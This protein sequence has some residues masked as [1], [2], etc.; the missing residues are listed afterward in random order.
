ML[1]SR[2]GLHKYK[3]FSIE[4]YPDGHWQMRSGAGNLLAGLPEMP[5]P[6]DELKASRNADRQIIYYDAVYRNDP[7]QV[8]AMARDIYRAGQ[9][10]HVGIIVAE[11]VGRRDEVKR[12]ARDMRMLTLA[13]V[14]VWFGVSDAAAGAVAQMRS[15][16]HRCGRSST[17][18][19]CTRHCPIWCTMPSTMPRP[20]PRS[21]YRSSGRR[22][23]WYAASP[24][25]DRAPA[26]SARMCECVFARFDRT[27]A[28]AAQ[29]HPGGSGLGLVIAGAYA[30]RNGSDIVL[31]D[32]EPNQAGGRGVQTDL[33]LPSALLQP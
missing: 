19:R 27:D 25:T 7:V 29:D 9:V 12:T 33:R 31:H 10:R 24:T 18:L 14:L 17:R 22:P 30:R 4:A 11:S 2:S 13:A 5:R 32:G 28:G 20:Q 16:R 8:V 23:A 6:P 21:R 26:P 3:Y 15:V 1:E